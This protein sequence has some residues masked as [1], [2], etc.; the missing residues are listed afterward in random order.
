M[1]SKPITRDLPF[2]LSY[3]WFQKH[4]RSHKVLGDSYA[5]TTFHFNPASCPQ[6]IYQLIEKNPLIISRTFKSSPQSD[7]TR[8]LINS[9]N[10]NLMIR[11]HLLKYEISPGKID[12]KIASERTAGLNMR[13]Y[14]WLRIIKLY[15]TP[16]NI[17]H[18]FHYWY[19]SVI[20]FYTHRC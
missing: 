8:H 9:N 16:L 15:S 13:R 17:K 20:S 4:L 2:Y 6:F 1:I 5:I 14:Y 7:A 10:T 11:T 3:D 12:R 18:N 19:I